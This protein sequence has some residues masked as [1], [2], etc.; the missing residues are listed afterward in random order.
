[1]TNEAFSN[2]TVGRL[3]ASEERLAFFIKKE[4]VSLP[5]VVLKSCA[6]T[7][8]ECRRLLQA[9]AC[10]PQ[11]L[12][13]AEEQ[14]AG[15]G[16]SG[17]SFFSPRQGGI[18]MS[19]LLRPQAESRRPAPQLNLITAAAGVCSSRALEEVTGA[20]VGIKWVN[21]LIYN[22]KKLGGILTESRWS[23]AGDLVGLVIGIGINVAENEA[24]FPPDLQELA[25]ALNLGEA[26]ATARLQ[27]IAK[28][29]AALVRLWYRQDWTAGL[30]EYRRRSGMAASF[31]CSLRPAPP[32]RR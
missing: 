32:I 23:G 18:Y 13:V 2:S 7:N 27:I 3:T 12:L 30:P 31:G 29:A 25:V 15:R 16:R 5:V 4:S 28:I 9:E 22:E 10:P 24:V 6:S 14:T 11:L 21:D 1:M 17:R 8:D 19:L 26:A 20:A